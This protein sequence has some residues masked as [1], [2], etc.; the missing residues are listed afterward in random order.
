MKIIESCAEVLRDILGCIGYQILHIKQEENS[1]YTVPRLVLFLSFPKPDYL[2]Y[3]CEL[4]LLLTFHNT[5]F[6]IPFL[7]VF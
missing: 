5:D 6:C 2:S 4:F 3:S 1:K 7:L